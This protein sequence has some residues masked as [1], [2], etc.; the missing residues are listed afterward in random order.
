MLR[1]TFRATAAVAR[2]PLP[3]IRQYAVRRG[4]DVDDA[5]LQ[6]ARQWLSKL[7]ADTISRDICE[8]SFSRSSGPGGQNVNKVSS[9]A[10]MRISL[11]SLLQRVPKV[12]HAFI[13]NSRYHAAKSDHLVIQ[14]DDSRKQSDNVNAC[15]RK[16][17]DLIMQAGRETVPGETSPEQMK[18]VD[19]LQKAEAAAR[20]KMKD[21]QSKK[22]SARR[23]GR[24]GD[25]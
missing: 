8:V 24:G 4:G 11:P 6:A 3:S 5:E 20:R 14:A 18:R 15:F 16:L 7:A 1:S 9:K 17:H 22:K 12:M 13:S 23:G 25:D 19:Q 2:A 10:T 21:H